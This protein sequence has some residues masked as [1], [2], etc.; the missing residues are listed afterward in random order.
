MK[1]LRISCLTL[2][3]VACIALIGPSAH[4][5]SK[6]MGV[7]MSTVTSYQAAS[8]AGLHCHGTC[9]ASGKTYDWTCPAGNNSAIP[10]CHLDCNARPPQP[11]EDCLFK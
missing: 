1:A 4:A 6:T 3:V 11:V 10:V 7:K 9:F 8:G 5:K 2:G